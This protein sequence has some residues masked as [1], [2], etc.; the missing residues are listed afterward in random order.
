MNLKTKYL[1]L[2]LKHPIVAS[3]SPLSK[4]L[5]GVKRLAEGGASAIVLFS[6]FEEQIRFEQESLE[7]LIGRSTY[8]SAESL[9]YFPAAAEFNA[10]PGEY[11]D[12]IYRASQAVDVPV[13]ASLNGVTELGWIEFAKDMVQAGARAIELNVYF[14]PVD[15]DLTSAQ[16]EEQ[17]VRVVDAVRAAVHVPVAV[18]LSPFFSSIGYMAQKLVNAGAD[19]LVLFNRFYQPDFDLVNRVVESKLELSHPAEIRLPLLWISVLHERLKVSLAATTGV[20]SAD[21]VLKYI[22]AG[23]DAVMTT[24]A[25]L[26]HGEK[27]VQTM[28]AGVREWMEA[29]EYESVQQMRGSMSQRNCA[30]PSAFVRANYLKMLQSYK[31]MYAVER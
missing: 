19:G 11:L 20:E 12:L 18:K 29:N 13:I 30:E 21:E 27:H 3:A 24:S 9:T 17:Y 26:R 1:G 22:L 16:V 14:L 15:L 6:L 5:D 25:L 2:E 31:G 8:S 28:L 10:G 7:F 23:A 4:N